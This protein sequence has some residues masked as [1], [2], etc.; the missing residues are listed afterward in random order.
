MS[1]PIDPFPETEISEYEKLR[2]KN[3]KER[4]DAMAKSGFF[5]DLIRY[6]KKIGLI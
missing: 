2:M 3:I 6:K 1:K 5:D 4:E